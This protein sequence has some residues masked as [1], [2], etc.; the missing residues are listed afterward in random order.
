MIDSIDQAA[1]KNGIQGTYDKNTIKC[2]NPEKPGTI[3][4]IK[5]KFVESFVRRFSSS[6]ERNKNYKI[7]FDD[8][9]ECPPKVTV[10]LTSTEPYSFFDRIFGTKNKNFDYESGTDIV[11]RLSAILESKE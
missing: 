2:D 3:R 7:S 11:N 5:E 4:I 10:T 8:I 1:N 9:N 6:A